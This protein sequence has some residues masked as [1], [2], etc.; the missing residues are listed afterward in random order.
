MTQDGLDFLT[1]FFPTIWQF[2]TSWKIPGT[3]TTPASWFFFLIV[4]GLV[5]NLLPQL[6]GVSWFKNR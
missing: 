2:F 6:F 1:W 4:A 3:G 5:L